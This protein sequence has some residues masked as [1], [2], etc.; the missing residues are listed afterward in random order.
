LALINVVLT[1]IIVLLLCF[2]FDCF[3]HS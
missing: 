1:V 3:S 2:S